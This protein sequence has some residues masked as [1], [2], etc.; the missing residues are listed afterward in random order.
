MG[1]DGFEIS[2]AV[3]EAAGWDTVR[4]VASEK[5]KEVSR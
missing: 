3:Q 1:S 4:E 2:A 5:V